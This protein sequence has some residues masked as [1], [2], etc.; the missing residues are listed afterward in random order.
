MDQPGPA[1]RDVERMGSDP[2]AAGNGGRT[3]SSV[4]GSPAAHMPPH[5]AHLALGMGARIGSA[6]STH[7]AGSSTAGAGRL[8]WQ[9]GGLGADLARLDIQSMVRAWH[10]AGPEGP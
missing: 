2:L 7:S 5:L 6:S 9:R 3:P 8:G 1:H 4:S 10:K